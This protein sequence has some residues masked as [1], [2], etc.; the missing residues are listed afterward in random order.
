LFVPPQEVSSE[1]VIDESNLSYH[2]ITQRPA[3]EL[4]VLPFSVFSQM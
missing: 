3:D 1:I 4:Q 2:Q